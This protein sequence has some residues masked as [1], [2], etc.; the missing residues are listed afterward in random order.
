MILAD[1][2]VRL[3][4]YQAPT[5]RGLNG[6]PV[7]V[8]NAWKSLP[9]RGALAPKKP[10]LA[11]TISPWSKANGLPVPLTACRLIRSVTRVMTAVSGRLDP[12]LKDKIAR[13]CFLVASSP[14]LKVVE[15]LSIFA[16]KLLFSPASRIQPSCE[17]TDVKVFVCVVTGTGV[18]VNGT[19]V[20]V[21]GTGVLVDGTGVLVDG[22]GVFVDGTGVF[23]DG[24][25]VFVDGTGVLVDGTGVLVDG[26]GVSVNGMGVSV[27]IG[28][29]VS[30]TGP[31][32]V[33][34]ASPTAIRYI[35]SPPAPDVLR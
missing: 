19:G 20:L 32:K 7:F 26:I 34:A 18:L 14:T 16:P 35:T 1:K 30:G 29:A 10:F 25:G 2:L 31:N 3:K 22:T 33:K 24:T 27:S 15:K 13:Y 4:L 6:P 5:G 8:A 21:D 12:V 23:V 28:V 11:S 17:P 9:T